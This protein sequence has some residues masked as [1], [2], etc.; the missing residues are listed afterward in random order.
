MSKIT[1]GKLGQISLK[2]LT[3]CTRIFREGN[4]EGLYY[5]DVVIGVLG[6]NCPKLNFKKL[7]F[8]C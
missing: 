6:Q 8:I 7:G 2:I 1:F 5:F 3:Q 4:I